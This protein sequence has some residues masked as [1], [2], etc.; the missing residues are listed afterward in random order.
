MR[1]D[2]VSVGRDAN[3]DADA[4]DM[5]FI[6]RKEMSRGKFWSSQDNK[7]INWKDFTYE[8]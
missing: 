7:Y 1:R 3:G 4:P 2:V 5:C 6:C 8:F